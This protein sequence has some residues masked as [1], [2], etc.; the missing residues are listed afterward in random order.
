MWSVVVF[1]LPLRI[2]HLQEPQVLAGYVRM[3]MGGMLMVAHSFQCDLE[4]KYDGHRIRC[5]TDENRYYT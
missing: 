2:L 3:C 1:N 4:P 5:H